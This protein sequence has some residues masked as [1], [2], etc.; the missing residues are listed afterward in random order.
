V[1][2]AYPSSKARPY[3]PSQLRPHLPC[4]TRRRSFLHDAG[5]LNPEHSRKLHAGRLSLSGEQLGAIDPE[6]LQRSPNILLI[7]GTSSIEHL[8]ENLKAAT[9]QIPAEILSDLDAII[10]HEKEI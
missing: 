10:R 1:Y 7:P 9:L 3:R 6:G 8:R 2:S 4:E 5:D